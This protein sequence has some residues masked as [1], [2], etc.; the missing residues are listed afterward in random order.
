[1]VE[2][3]LGRNESVKSDKILTLDGREISPRDI[4]ALIEAGQSWSSLQFPRLAK[5][6]NLPFSLPY[7]NDPRLVGVRP[8]DE[9]IRAPGTICEPAIIYCTW[10]SVGSNVSFE[11]VKKQLRAF[12]NLLIHPDIFIIDE[13]WESKPGDWQSVDRKKFPKGLEEATQLIHQSSM[14]AWLWW[15]PFNV[16]QKSVLAQDH[17]SWLATGKNAGQPVSFG[18]EKSCMMPAHFILDPRNKDAWEYLENV[19]L[20]IKKRGFDGV[21]ADFLTNVFLIPRIDPQEALLYVHNILK[22]IKKA[23]LK[24]EG[25]CCPF[26]AALGVADYIRVTNDSGLPKG[27]NPEIAGKINH[28]MVDGVVRGVKER[29]DLARKFGVIPDPDM[30]Y[31]FDL[32]WQDIKRLSDTQEWSIQHG[33]CLT[34]G[35]DF[36]ELARL[37]KT[38]KGQV[39]VIRQIELN[40]RLI[41]QFHAH[42][43]SHK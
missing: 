1:M 17:R 2:Q 25:C 16:S 12:N 34:L 6:L 26:S 42:Y 43:P 15:G 21:K 31:Q 11:F 37:Q 41:N 3:E 19:A 14:E 30:F 7:C 9:W 27:M 23:G 18:I 40:R 36:S 10:A 28:I 5:A 35:D 4:A 32:G 39:Q 20:Q 24:V 13:G 29:T 38:E 33:G 8:P 22:T